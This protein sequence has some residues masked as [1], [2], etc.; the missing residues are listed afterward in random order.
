MPP[1]GM[2]AYRLFS[3]ENR[4][5][6]QSALKFDGKPAAMSDVAKV[7]G[8]KWRE[9]SDESKKARAHAWATL[10]RL[11][12]CFPCSP[13]PLLTPTRLIATQVFLDQAGAAV[14]SCG[15]RCLKQPADVRLCLPSPAAGCRSCCSC[16]C[17]RG[18]GGHRRGA[19]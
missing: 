14:R 17:R 1:L 15:W 18:R 4:Q 13:P 5:E 6:V 10:P 3:N 11:G 19:G 9:L 7:L 12:R 8:Q 16:P 2:H